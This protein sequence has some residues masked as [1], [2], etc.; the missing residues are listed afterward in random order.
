MS[1]HESYP[2][3]GGSPVPPP[4][5]PPPPYGGSPYPPPP[6][7]GWPPVGPG[8]PAP[9]YPAWQP[10]PGMLGAAH[11]PGAIPLRPLGL[12]D[13]YDGAFKIIRYNPKVTVG[14]PVLVSALA[15]LIPVLLSVVLTWTAGSALD[16]E[17]DG[18]D[19]STGETV[20]LIALIGSFV[21]GVLAQ[22]VGSLLVTGMIAHV[23][24][25]AAVG[26]RLG[27]AEAWRA[28][29][30]K[31]WRIL[32]LALLLG[33]VY[34]VGLAAYVGL[35]VVL[36]LAIDSTAFL[37][38]FGLVSGP[39]VIALSAFLYIRFT[40]V[41]VPALVLE[42]VGMVGAVRRCFRLTS[43][44]FWRTFG[45]SLLTVVLA[46]VASM[47]L[48]CPLSLVGGV[49]TLTVSPE[50]ELLAN[51]VAQAVTTVLSAALITPFVTTVST[52]QYVDLRMRKEA[53]DVELMTRAGIVA[54]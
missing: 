54:S 28:T 35:W 22:S 27:L 32:G 7:A 48:T 3:P 4:G 45:I 2:P 12:G 52:L 17:A 1:G 14:A 41:A 15:L 5:S 46:Y 53:F 39:A 10:A 47:V 29:Y 51:V 16:A 49:L 34:L 44:A 43:G 36:A 31:R 42:D 33:L 20:A 30:G 37:V 25:A 38:V 11:K 18:A 19:L 50:Y 9:S 8:G 23:V 24:L 26:R 13:L 6:P 21:L 40:Y